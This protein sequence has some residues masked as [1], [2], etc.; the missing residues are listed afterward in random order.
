MMR[1]SKA[2]G[3][4]APLIIFGAIIA[5]LLMVFGPLI[6]STSLSV[7][8]TRQVAG[9]FLNNLAEQ[10]FANAFEQV[11]FFDKSS[12]LEPQISYDEAKEIWL[13][14][15]EKL[16]QEGTYIV[17]FH[18]LNTWTDD[19]YPKGEV[20]IQVAESNNTQSYRASI[21]FFKQK[22]KWMV[23]S[24]NIEGNNKQVSLEKALSGFVGE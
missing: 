6:I 18:D 14:R 21:H 10:D 23:Q 12:D 17:S 2:S 7:F 16:Q 4:K 5:F 15:V 24:I 3:Y 8:Q 9:E 1:I 11:A 20:Q 19:T 13:N 22:G